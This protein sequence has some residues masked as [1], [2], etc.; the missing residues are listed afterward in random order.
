MEPAAFQI[1]KSPVYLEPIKALKLRFLAGLEIE[2]AVKHKGG[3]SVEP[4]ITEAVRGL[5]K[6]N[7]QFVATLNLNPNRGTETVNSGT[8]H[9]RC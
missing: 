5:L 3:G 7:F 2:S 1:R 6:G 8:D 4:N 9:G